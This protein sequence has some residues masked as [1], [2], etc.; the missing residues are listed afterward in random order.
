MKKAKVVVILAL[1]LALLLALVLAIGGHAQGPGGDEKNEEGGVGGLGLADPPPAG[2][3]V[4]YTFTGAT[5]AQDRTPN[6]AATVVHCTNYGDTAVNV[7]VEFGDWD[8]SPV[9]SCTTSIASNYT[10]TFSSQSPVSFYGLHCI[11]ST[12][13]TDDINQGFGRIM[14][15]SSSAKI[16]C[17][18][19]VVDPINN[20]PRYGVKLTLFDSSGNLIGGM[21]KI[22]LPIILKS[23]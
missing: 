7:C 12:P 3:T 11:M 14:A 4:L 5:D 16:I 2:Y 10:K 19:Q 18:A 22:Y 15:D 21:P 23:H 8:N 13:S 17:T 9:I 6:S 20:P 1:S